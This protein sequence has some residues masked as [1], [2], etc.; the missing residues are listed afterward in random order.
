MAQKTFDICIRGAGV[1]GRTLALLLASERLRVALVVPN[2][3]T[4]TVDVRAYALNSASQNLLQLLRAWPDAQHAT[5]VRHM[6]VHGDAQSS[7]HFDAGSH[8]VQALTWIVDVPALEQHLS[9]AVRYQPLIEVVHQPVEAALTVICEGRASATRQELGVEFDVTPYAQTAIATRLTCSEPHGQIARQWFSPLGI[10]AFLPLQGPQGH[11]VAVVWSAPQALAPQ[12]VDAEPESFV[13]MLDSMSQG[14]L[15]QLT[16]DGPRLSWPLQQAQ[17]QRWCGVWPNSTV[18]QPMSWV[19]AGDAAHN[20]HPLAGQGLNLGLADVQALADILRSRP[21]WRSPG[22]LKLLRRYERERKA[23]WLP[24]G[25]T[26]DGLQQLFTRPESG[27]QMLRNW[28][29]NQ[30]ERCSLVK[31]WAARQAMGLAHDY[32]EPS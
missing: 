13:D 31:D 19:L 11:S 22:D 16:L 29:M 10:L 8:N 25:L 5:A 23:A 17:A 15:G 18:Q 26:M 7:V 9:D 14:A 2:H 12:W 27:V 3:P 6:E 24:M 20:V 28:G 1:V 32:R 30:F 21:A 4:A